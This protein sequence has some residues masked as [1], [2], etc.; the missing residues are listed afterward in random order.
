MYIHLGGDR[1]I[2][3]S[4]IVAIFDVQIHET[5]KL[6]GMFLQKMP[7]E[8]I[9]RIISDETVK[10]YVVTK[11]KVYLSPISSSTLKKRAQV[12]TAL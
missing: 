5:S 10:S 7:Q 4:Q 6:H 8:R 1:I 9:I 3:T 11:E 12:V 2:K